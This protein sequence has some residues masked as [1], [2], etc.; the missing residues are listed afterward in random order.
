MSRRH[1]MLPTL[2]AIGLAHATAAQAAANINIVNLDAGTG[3]GLDDPTPMAPGGGNAGTTR[4][5]QARIVFQFA[6]DLWGSVLE[7]DVDIINT[8]T[9]QPLS[10]DA[11]SGV[12]GS[13]G[14]NYIFSFN[15]PAPA[16]ALTGTWY[17]SAL[18][19]ALGGVDA[20]SENGLPANTPDILS[21]F[22]GRL[23][24]PGCLDGSGWYFGLD[25]NTP[26]N[27]ISLL[28][29]IMHEM[30]HGL[31][32]SGF[33]NL[34]TGAMNQGQQDIY[35]TFVK[36]NAT[37]KAWT[38]MTDIE[39][40]AAAINDSHLVFTGSNVKGESPLALGPLFTFTVTSPAAIAGIYD[41][42]AAAFG[43]ALSPANFAGSV[44]VPSDPLACGTVDSGVS[45]KVALIDRGTCAFAIKVKNAQLAG[46]TAVI[47][48]NNAAGAI[49]PA[50]VD[51]TITIPTIGITQAD[52]NTFKANLASLAVAFVDSG[53]RA[54]TDSD[55]NVQLYAPVVLA[56]GSSFSHYDTRLSPNAIM[57]YAINADLQGMYSLDLTPALFK[58]L[59]WQINRGNQFL[60]D[61]NTG[62]P[63]S[64]PGGP[65]MGAN[66]YGRARAFAAN[67]ADLA[68]YR[69]GIRAHAAALQ[70]EG[71]L[72]S[73]QYSSV[74]LCLSD[75]ATAAQFDEWG[76]A[77]GTGPVAVELTNK[78]NVTGVAGAAAS[79]KLYSFEASAGSV[80]T[81]MTLGGTGNVSL[82][83]SFEEEPTATVFDFKSSRP[84]NSETVRINTPQ[85]GTYYVKLVGESAY[86][87]V[88]LVARQ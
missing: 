50:G 24:L 11:T 62:V 45:G 56:Q 4:G 49:A 64:I 53:R 79:E 73:G 85:A 21:R 14:T 65:I 82:Y 27:R 83:V 72:T 58:D 26:A 51:A 78:T 22:N 16:G 77:V 29:V 68:V 67:A 17:H 6:A 54:G 71:L 86:S 35:S 23:G 2:L 7:S 25:G 57:E 44:V 39:R 18:T 69:T 87:G 81:I 76:N 36:D 33:N 74:L 48:A 34:S 37:G 13:S 40:K 30:A 28:D 88:T 1:W 52:G 70:A 10:C 46:A 9:F 38:S 47:L 84:G 8:A 75:A 43:P 12:L 55:G 19:D 3:T 42:N 63:T 41:Y 59:G 5:E 80:V 20:A 66:L 60:L 31:G 61:C 32:F 15:A